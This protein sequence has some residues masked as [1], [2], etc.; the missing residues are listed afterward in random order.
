MGH[1]GPEWEALGEEAW[2]S[3]TL[4]AWDMKESLW[5]EE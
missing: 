4:E 5:P 2:L 1:S 3:D